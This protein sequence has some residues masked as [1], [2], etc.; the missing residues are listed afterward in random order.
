MSLVLSSAIC[1]AETRTITHNFQSMYDSGTLTVNTPT[2]TIGTTAETTYT[3]SGGAEFWKTDA[4]GNELAIFLNASGRQVVTTAIQ[5]LDSLRIYY[6]PISKQNITVSIREEGGVWTDV[7]VVKKENGMSTVKMP[8]VGNYQIRI[9][10]S[11][12]VYIK[13]IRYILYFDLSGCPNCFIYTP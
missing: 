1:R 9:Q 5:N 11:D 7:T 12:N 6:A 10:R 8:S 4:S 3:C 2:N 13:E